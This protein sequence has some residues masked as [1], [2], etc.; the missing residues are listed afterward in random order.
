MTGITELVFA[1]LLVAGLYASR[2]LWGS[3][4]KLKAKEL[5]IGNADREV[6]LQPKIKAV[7]NK[8]EACIKTNGKWLTL[9]DLKQI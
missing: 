8:Q 3:Y 6:E 9:D 4:F 7:M 1:A 2:N 5:E